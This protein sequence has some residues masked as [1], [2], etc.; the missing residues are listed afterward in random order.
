MNS[1]LV[2]RLS[3]LGDVIHTM[4]AVLALANSLRPQTRI[5][6]VVEAPLAPLVEA[7]AQV[8]DVYRVAT[9]HWRRHPLSGETYQDLRDL[10]GVLRG[11]ARGETSIDFQGLVKSAALGFSSSASRRIGF[12]RPSLRESMAS[13][14]YTERVEVDPTAHVVEQ[15][16]MLA[17]SAGAQAVRPP[18]PDYSRFPADHQG[19]LEALTAPRP[20]VLLPGAGRPSKQWNIDRYGELADRLAKSLN[21]KAIVAW[22]P[23]EQHLAEAVA[24]RGAATVAPPTDL[25]QLAFLLRGARLVIGGD[26]G[27]LHLADALGTPVIG[28]YGPTNPR[29]NGPYHQI[30]RC[31]ETFS[32][33]RN[34]DDIKVDEVMA[35]AQELVG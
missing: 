18:V 22:G 8:D 20:V 13:V 2:L 30:G 34:M 35:R 16:M 15:N 24:A 31:L 29:R 3:A 26:T 21:L 10:R 9:R 12:A 33:T 32:S 28:L 5:G 1:L 6:W 4:P 27:P 19:T 23:G 25:S 17:H 11:F 14:F 7:V